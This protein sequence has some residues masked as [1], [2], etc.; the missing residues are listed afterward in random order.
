MSGKFSYKPF[1]EINLNELLEIIMKRLKPLA[2][3]RGIEILRRH[4]EELGLNANNF[5]KNYE[6]PNA[7]Y[8]LDGFDEIGTQSWST[9][10]KV[11]QQNRANSVCAVKDLV[12]KVQGGVLIAGRDYYFN[13]DAEM[14]SC[15][16]LSLSDTIILECNSEFKESEIIDFI[17]ENI[18]EDDG[19]EKLQHLP[20]WLPKRPLVIQLLLKYAGDIF[21]VEHA[22]DDVCSFWYVFLN[23]MC[24]RE[25]KIYA[26][27]LV[28]INSFSLYIHTMLSR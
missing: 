16:G 17:K 13:S 5:I 12:G 19:A 27:P 14:C 28:M 22:L 8:L 23:K 25:A 24:Q 20:V 10:V 21:T 4:F 7:I 2:L 3:K 18:G 15:L 26:L 6:R 11:M 1:A 9:D